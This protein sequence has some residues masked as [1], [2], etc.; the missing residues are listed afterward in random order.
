MDHT[1]YKICVP[2]IITNNHK[3]REKGEPWRNTSIS[4]LKKDRCYTWS[5]TPFSGSLVMEHIAGSSRWAI[6]LRVKKFWVAAMPRTPA[7]LAGGKGSFR[8]RRKA[9][10][11]IFCLTYNRITIKEWK[12]FLFLITCI[13]G[14]IFITWRGDNLH[15]LYA[16]L[17]ALHSNWR[18]ECCLLIQYMY[19][20]EL[21]KA[22]F[23]YHI[24]KNIK[25]YNIPFYWKFKANQLAYLGVKMT[26]YLP[27]T[28][29]CVC[30]YSTLQS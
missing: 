27:Q 12:S 20:C 18:Q 16:L 23:I 13:T 15:G 26:G 8:A 1:T 21:S 4:N 9:E 24:L 28:Y 22:Y 11:I 10:D 6:S 5:L 14:H 25:F 2:M 29:S 19:T 17:F 3:L 30:P 7:C